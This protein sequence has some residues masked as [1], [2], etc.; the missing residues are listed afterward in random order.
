MYPW[1]SADLEIPGGWGEIIIYFLFLY[2]LECIKTALF[3]IPEI[4]KVPTVGGGGP[5]P[6]P[7][8]P[9]ARSLRSLDA[10]SIRLLAKLSSSVF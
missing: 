10:W 5:A 7:H 4:P 1:I 8:P 2:T 9:T 3:F 6:L